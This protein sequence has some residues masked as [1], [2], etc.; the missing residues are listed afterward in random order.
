MEQILQTERQEAS[1]PGA[2]SAMQLSCAPCGREVLPHPGQTAVGRTFP[3]TN[4]LRNAADVTHAPVCR[5]VEWAHK[6][7]VK[8]F[9]S[10]CRKAFLP[11]SSHAG[12]QVQYVCVCFYFLGWRCVSWPGEREH[13]GG[14]LSGKLTL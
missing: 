11:P 12:P 1:C 6:Q 7:Q 3:V 2:L 4:S 13:G 8:Q 14:L 9:L 5:A 10:R